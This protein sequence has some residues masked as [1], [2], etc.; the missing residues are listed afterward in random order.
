MCAVL[1]SA[2]HSFGADF[3]RAISRK[4]ERGRFLVIGANPQELKSQFA[5]AEREAEVWSYDDLASSLSRGA[6]IAD[7]ETAVWFYPSEKNEDY[8]VA[9]ALSGCA[10]AIVLMPCPGR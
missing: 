5:E 4:F 1:P 7:F 10:D 3:A 9:E 6:G 8:A 2:F